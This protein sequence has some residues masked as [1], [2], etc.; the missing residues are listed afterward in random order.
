MAI[1]PLNKHSQGWH[2]E[3]QLCLRRRRS[4]AVE[5]WD[6]D[7]E[8]LTIVMIAALTGFT[9]RVSDVSSGTE[10]TQFARFTYEEEP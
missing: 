1:K 4:F 5:N 2:E 7:R 3:A 9:Y 10:R 8:S 6:S